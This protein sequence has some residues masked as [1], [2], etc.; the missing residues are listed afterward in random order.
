MKTYKV[1]YNKKY[2]KRGSGHKASQA[3]HA[4]AGLCS[5]NPQCLYEEDDKVI[6][7]EANNGPFMRAYE[8]CEGVKFIQ[9]DYAE[10]HGVGQGEYTA[11][12]TIV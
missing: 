7:V 6:I 12:A 2:S 4:I 9:C 11:W 5:A 3:A 10:E 1:T 8:E